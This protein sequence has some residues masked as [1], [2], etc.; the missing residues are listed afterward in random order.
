MAQILKGMHLIANSHITEVKGERLFG[1][2]NESQ[3]VLLDA[4]KRSCNGLIFVDVDSVRFGDDRAYNSRNIEQ[5]LLKLKE[6]TVEA[7]G[8]CA[9]IVADLDA[10]HGDVAEELSRVGIYEFDHTLLFNDFTPEELYEILCSCLARLGV[11]FT[12]E[13]EGH[14]R[15]YLRAMSGSVGANA[16]TM[17]LMARTI[18]QQV[19]LREAALAGRPASHYVELSDVETFKWNGKR[20]R[21]GF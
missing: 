10:P 17:K 9:L 2:Y 21:I 14:M 4:V 16:R 19:I 12:P 18:H 1:S 5:A 7:G 20:G 13:A 11:S 8:E 15:E 6:M 3:A